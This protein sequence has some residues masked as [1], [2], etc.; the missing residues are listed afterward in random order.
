M[1]RDLVVKA[2]IG[3]TGAFRALALASHARLYKV[4]Q[5]ILRD[6]HLAED[7][8][9]QAMLDIWRYIKRLRD[10]EKFDGWSYRLVVHAC[11]AES[12]RKATWLPESEMQGR[13]QPLASDDYGT[14]IHRDQL[15]R[16]F[17]GL[18]LEHR[19][20]VVLHHLVGMPLQQVADTLDIRLGT[21]KS[22]LH[23]AMQELRAAIEADA[24]T[25][26]PRPAP[27]EVVR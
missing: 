25:S 13:R 9:Q 3:D 8:T 7:A 10:P 6:P 21:V 22:R 20:V 26:E 17:R 19:T 27:Q 24:R 4:A 14:V 23:R 5:G 15:E 2:Q 1:D 16:G 12:K 18:S 11:Y